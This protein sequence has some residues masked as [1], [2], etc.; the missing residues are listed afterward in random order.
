MTKK[1]KHD[2]PVNID[3]DFEEAMQ[4]LSNVPKSQ[5]EANIKRHNKKKKN[6]E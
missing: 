6:N 3:M 1:N 2:K 5:V 4:R